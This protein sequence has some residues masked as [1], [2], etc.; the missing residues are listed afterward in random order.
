MSNIHWI[1]NESFE[2][3]FTTREKENCSHFLPRTM[4]MRRWLKNDFELKALL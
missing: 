1:E 3:G 4:Q 2:I